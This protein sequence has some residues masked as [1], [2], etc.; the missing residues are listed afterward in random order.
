MVE[1]GFNDIQPSA[2]CN[3]D[4]LEEGAFR[5]CINSIACNIVVILV[6]SALISVDLFRACL[7]SKEVRRQQCMLWT[8][9]IAWSMLHIA[10]SHT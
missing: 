6:S 9:S 3:D 5:F 8:N 4:E 10:H 2:F 7:S 1:F